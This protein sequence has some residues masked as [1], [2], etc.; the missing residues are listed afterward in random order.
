MVSLSA[1]VGRRTL[2]SSDSVEIPRADFVKL[3]RLAVLFAE[4][5]DG[6]EY[7][8]RSGAR[9]DSGELLELAECARLDARDAG[10][11]A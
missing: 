2:P 4:L 3:A 11:G 10:L 8:G 6:L 7:L 5:V 1:R 9:L